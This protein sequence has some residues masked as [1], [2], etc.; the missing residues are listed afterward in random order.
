RHAD[1]YCAF[2]TLAATLICFKQLT[3]TTT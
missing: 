2:A 1:N 3:K